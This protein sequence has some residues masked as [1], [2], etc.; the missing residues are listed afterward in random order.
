MR[1]TKPRSAGRSAK[2]RPAG[3]GRTTRGRTARAV[4]RWR[5]SRLRRYTAPHTATPTMSRRALPPTLPMLLA[6]C[7]LLAGCAPPSDA[8]DESSVRLLATPLEK[9]GVTF[10]DVN[11]EPYD[12]RARTEGFRTLPFFGYT[13]SPDICPVQMANLGAVL[14]D[15]PAETSGRIKVVFVTTDPERDTAERL[16]EWL[17]AI[18]PAIVGLR[19]PLEQV[20]AAEMTLQ[21]PQSVVEAPQGSGHAD[22]FVGHAAPVVVFDADGL[23][24]RMYPAGTRQQDWRRDLPALVTGDPPTPAGGG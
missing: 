20:H 6:A 19:A 21:L 11:G 13:H 18:H 24:R 2:R 12:L 9:P 17:G 8:A 14:R 10:T 1:G 22:Y 23:A 4:R 5:T 15:R 3:N 7:A 16:R